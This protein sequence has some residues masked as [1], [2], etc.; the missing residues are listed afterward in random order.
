V[1]FKEA[2]VAE[3]GSPERFSENVDAFLEDK[4][5]GNAI[6]PMSL[7]ACRDSM[8]FF[9]AV[10][11]GRVVSELSCKDGTPTLLSSRLDTKNRSPLYLGVDF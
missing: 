4:Q 8:Q 6:S 2:Q 3:V 9:V 7:Q 5:A 10:M 1:G 11:G